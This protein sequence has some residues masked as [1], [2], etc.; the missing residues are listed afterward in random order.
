MTASYYTGSLACV[1]C[2]APYPDPSLPLVGRGCPAC[3]LD[4]APSN[5]LPVYDVP[6][7]AGLPLAGDQPGLFRHRALL[8]LRP[9]TPAVSLGEG[10][11]PLVPLERTAARLGLGGLHVKD[12]TRNPT[13]SYKD[14]LASVAVT[15]AVELGVEA[16]VV[17]STGNHG[18]AVAA[19]A[20]RAGLPC[21]VLTVASVPEAMK[22]L[23][24]V[25]GARVVA[26]E[27]A[28]DR[29]T[30]MRELVEKRGWLA[31]SGHAAPPV[32]S[33]GF[34]V[35][36][37]KTIAYEIVSDLGAVPDVV[38]VP[39]SYADGLAGIQRGFAD[40][41]TLGVAPHMPR[42]IA[43][44]RFGPH[45]GALAA[46]TDTPGPVPADATVAFSIG[47]P[48]GTYQGLAALRASGGAA[49]PVGDDTRI[50]DAQRR[51]GRESG[52]YLEAS[53]V[54]AVL[55]VEELGLPEGSTV[56]V[57][58]TSTGLKDIGA[59]SATL[60]AVPVIE[61]TVAAMD[62]ALETAAR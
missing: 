41:V 60:P 55:A 40:L 9:G 44:E 39:V 34:G 10:G 29:W 33:I 2:A 32:G 15:K 35:D 30:L 6:R 36:G 25:Y 47:S 21:V 45:A 38:V 27:H 14:R 58:G 61:P 49:V 11:T 54:T 51:L 7:G 17:A 28:P 16:V 57:V 19:Y 24:Q 53:S 12:E 46:G 23:M 1:R 42:M 8:P 3:E 20:A 31:L 4:G 59:T 5:V 56:V 50:L 22:T 13:W 43:A 26:L 37:Y 52:L 18:A 62:S 48:Y